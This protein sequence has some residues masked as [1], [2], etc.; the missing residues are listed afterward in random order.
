MMG[1][2]ALEYSKARR[3]IVGTA[4]LPKLADKVKALSKRLDIL[5]AAENDKE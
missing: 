1:I 5:E 4:K 2:P 3:V